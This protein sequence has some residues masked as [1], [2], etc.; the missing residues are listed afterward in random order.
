MTGATSSECLDENT[1]AELSHGLLSDEAVRQLEAHVDHCA[2]C[3]NVDNRDTIF[4]NINK[5]NY[6]LDTLRSVANKYAV[7]VAVAVSVKLVPKILLWLTGWLVMAGAVP[8]PT[9]LAPGVGAAA[10]QFVASFA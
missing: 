2:P 9:K 1:V 5:D 7:P 6:R 10:V 3:L 8:P 4:L